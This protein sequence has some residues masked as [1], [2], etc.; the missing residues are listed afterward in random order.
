[1]L[2]RVELTTREVHVPLHFGRDDLHATGHP[3]AG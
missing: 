3:Q 1:M 2:S